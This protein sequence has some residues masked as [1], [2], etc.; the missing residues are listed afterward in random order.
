MIPVLTK[1]R[2]ATKKK[3]QRKNAYETNKQKA[4]NQYMCTVISRANEMII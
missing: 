4:M 1:Q 2:T 3:E